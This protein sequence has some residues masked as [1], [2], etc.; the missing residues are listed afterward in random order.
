MVDFVM[1]RELRDET[2]RKALRFVEENRGAVAR[3]AREVE[4]VTGGS[5][6]EG[7]AC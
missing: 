7:E 1:D 4:A 3:A 2:G 6:R 5:G